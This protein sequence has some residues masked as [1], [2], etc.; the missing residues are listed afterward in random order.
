[1]TQPNANELR[2]LGLASLAHRCA[3]ETD[4]FF[5]R[6]AY[7]PAYCFELF[8]R[9]IVTGD[10]KAHERLYVQYQSLVAG[11]VERH[12]SYPS[13]GEEAQYFV[14]RAFEK[15]WRALTP[16]KFGQ[17]TDLKA[18]LAYLK[19][20]THSTIVDFSRSHRH[21]IG[22]DEPSPEII[23]SGPGSGGD[24]EDDAVR[25]AQR[26]DFWR[27]IDERISGEKERA[28]IYGSFVHA[29]KPA[30]LHA[31]YAPLFSDVKDVY[32]TKQNVIE[33]LRR[34]ETLMS[35]LSSQA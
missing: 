12:P 1:M 26:T 28:V 14:N 15:L 8:R 17:F 29:M 35:Y 32:R 6:E 10:Q 3:Q 13:T 23:A 16:A 11:W 21:L 22:D 30:E 20:C 31:H 25:Q 24:V 4:L 33:R 18:L 7:D 19:M 27:L 9:A 34:D 5:K 2:T